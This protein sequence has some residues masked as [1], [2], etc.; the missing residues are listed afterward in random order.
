MKPL[1]YTALALFL[2]LIQPRVTL[3]QWVKV[4][5]STSVVSFAASAT[6]LFAGADEEP[7]RVTGFT[8]FNSTS[9]G[10]SWA[11]VGNSPG[12]TCVDALAVSG[13]N[14]IA[15]TD[16]GYYGTGVYVSTNS[17]ASW[18]ATGPSLMRLFSLATRGQYVFAGSTGSVF[19][20]PDN[21]VNW[22]ATNNGLP[23][24]FVVA[25]CV[26]GTNL[27]AGT[28]GGGVYFSTNDGASW[29]SASSGLTNS[30]VNA[31]AAIGDNVFAGTWG[32]GIFLS[33]NNGASWTPA[34]NGLTNN[35]VFALA[36]SG[37]NLFAG[38]GPNGGVFL[39]TNNGASWT[40]ANDGLINT[41]VRALVVSGPYLFAGTSGGVWRRSLSELVSVNGGHL[42]LPENFRLGQNYPNP[43]NPSTTIDYQIAA[44]SHVVLS[45]F[46][47]L[48]REVSSLVNAIQEPGYK[49]VQWD[50]TNVASGLY[51]YQLRAGS[52]VETKKMLLVR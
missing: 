13:Q 38:T 23:N 14:L 47:V 33:T 15:G 5:D 3:S 39:S 49:S 26:S 44:R 48:G 52:F 4:I 30:G 32:S 34:N 46:D 20:S 35:N 31:L 43:F 37:G 17:G 27:F 24:T 51:F 10:S 22:T 40:S 21:G 8:V 36:A 28:D 2:V 42:T 41:F 6:H 18:T 7:F 1:C 50:A 12:G 19:L 9:N 25:L 16:G 45:V 11:N 29:T